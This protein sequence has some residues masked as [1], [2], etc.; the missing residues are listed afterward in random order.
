M[1]FKQRTVQDASKRMF[2]D[3]R[4]SLKQD[5]QAIQNLEWQLGTQETALKRRNDA[6]ARHD[7]MQL[8]D[9]AAATKHSTEGKRKT[10][11]AFKDLIAVDGPAWDLL[12]HQVEK[13]KQKSQDYHYDQEK[14]KINAAGG[15][16]ADKIHGQQTEARQ[17]IAEI[18]PELIKTLGLE[19][20][21][22]SGSIV[23]KESTWTAEDERNKD[24]VDYIRGAQKVQTTGAVL[25]SSAASNDIVTQT[26]LTSGL[27]GAFGGRVGAAQG[28]ALARA[29]SFHNG[30]LGW[31]EGDTIPRTFTYKGKEYEYKTSELTEDYLSQETPIPYLNSVDAYANQILMDARKAGLSNDYMQ[32]Y[33][34]PIV[35]RKAGE[36]KGTYRKEW[37]AAKNGQWVKEVHS[38]VAHDFKTAIG[39]ND[40]QAV[41]AFITTLPQSLRQLQ[42]YNGRLKIKNPKVQSMKDLLSTLRSAGAANIELTEDKS[43]GLEHLKDAK[44][45]VSQVPWVSKNQ[46]DPDGMV[47]MSVAFP[48][49]WS[50]EKI[51]KMNADALKEYVQIQEETRG[52]QAKIDAKAVEQCYLTEGHGSVGCKEQE[53]KWHQTYS[54]DYQEL[55]KKLKDKSTLMRD[56]KTTFKFLKD[57]ETINGFITDQDLMFSN[58]E[59]I[60]LYKEQLPADKSWESI[61]EPVAIDKQVPEKDAKD[62]YKQVDSI[63]LKD[64]LGT[65]DSTA[66]N[67]T[68]TEQILKITKEEIIPQNMRDIAKEYK[69]QNA[70]VPDAGELMRLAVDKLRKEAELSNPDGGLK[71]PRRFSAAKDKS[72]GLIHFFP[73]YSKSAPDIGMETNKD[74]VIAATYR[75]K[76]ADLNVNN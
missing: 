11:Q 44:I 62:Y 75:E 69:A 21:Q 12:E 40:P 35:N 32:R 74:A 15:F 2:E 57:Q 59:G 25:T 46:A 31:S 38:S 60:N 5:T 28:I 52:Y 76:Q 64:I 63:I 41:A 51:D 42:E 3:A 7:A 53:H 36:L 50:D 68:L 20:Q 6:A 26:E 72:S 61:Y 16:G 17:A 22:K 73:N 43:T 1:V 71:T 67:S 49:E 19:V 9:F 30:Y 56:T 29:E 37:A 27:F 55:S 23:V 39:T 48:K 33:I 45:H 54:R 4:V 70:N 65:S 10:W 18:D 58:T 8:K 47:K 14:K 24:A 34:T 66:I 13:N